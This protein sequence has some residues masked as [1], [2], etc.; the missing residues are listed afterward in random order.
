MTKKCIY[1]NTEISE[2]SVV[3]ICEKCGFGVWGPKMFKTIVR[4]MEGAKEKGNLNQ[5]YVGET[6]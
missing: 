2:S 1:C 4:N 3:E 5:G 6:R